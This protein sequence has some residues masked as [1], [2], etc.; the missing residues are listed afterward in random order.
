[1]STISLEAAIRT[2]K[3][4]TAYANKVESD[5]FLNPENMVCPIWNGMDSAGRRVS[6]DSY[7]TKRAGCNSAEDRVVVENNQRPQYMEY[8]NLS[9]NGIDGSIYGNTM[10]WVEVGANRAQFSYTDNTSDPNNV[11]NITGNFGKQLS[12][13]VYPACGYY[14]YAQAMAQ[15]EQVKRQQQALQEGYW[16]N[17][18]RM[19]SG[20]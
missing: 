15:E 20:F 5:R 14:P 10:P 18:Y 7:Y 6:P 16:A 19:S 13:S 9:A 12:A 1:M 17:N 11:N 4:D 8:I 2:C 3:V